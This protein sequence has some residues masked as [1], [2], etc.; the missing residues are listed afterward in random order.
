MVCAPANL[1]VVV[2]FWIQALTADRAAANAPALAV[3]GTLMA[4][5]Q[6]R[7][8]DLAD[9]GVL[10]HDK[11]PTGITGELLGAENLA[12]APAG[13]QVEQVEALLLADPPHAA[14]VLNP[15]YNAVGLGVAVRADGQLVYV[16]A[17]GTVAT[18]ATEAAP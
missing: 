12:L 7:A 6:F 16:Q 15:A 1:A 10:A 18:V 14:N 9:R 2:A 4:W 17:F 3:D 13:Y 5:A 8:D 11:W